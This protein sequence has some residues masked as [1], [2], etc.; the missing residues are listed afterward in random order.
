MKKTFPSLSLIETYGIE[1]YNRVQQAQRILTYII[2][3]LDSIGAPVSLMYGT[4]L[5]EFRNGTGPCVQ[6]NFKDKDFDIAVFETHFQD[7]VA[8]SGNIKS[9]FG[10]DV[11]SLEESR[12]FISFF[13]SG[14]ILRS[15]NRYQIDVYGFKSDYPKIGLI[16]FPWDMVTVAKDAFLPLVK[17]KA[18]AYED[19]Q[20]ASNYKKELYFYKPFNVP[21]LL[22]NMYG[23][24]FMTPKDGHFIRRKAYGDPKCDHKELTNN[25]EE[26]FEK[27]RKY[28]TTMVSRSSTDKDATSRQDKN[29]TN[30]GN[31]G[32][33]SC[34]R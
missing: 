21:C 34:V 10:W 32:F 33:I 8:M 31:A 3:K 15:P 5:H 11:G 24:D 30:V 1:K 23:S 22:P 27:K 26:E 29:T 7:V 18:I 4:L 16:R 14:Q 20:T 13:P 17:H 19:K 28:G 9:K 6:F 12:M 2:E 25:E